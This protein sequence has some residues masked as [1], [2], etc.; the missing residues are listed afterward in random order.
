MDLK[1]FHSNNHTI[2]QQSPKVDM[3]KSC[4]M[5]HMTHYYGSLKKKISCGFERKLISKLAT[6]KLGFVPYNLELLD[7][8]SIFS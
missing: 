6:S 2:K 3:Y 7:I 5:Q 8:L 1:L 4:S